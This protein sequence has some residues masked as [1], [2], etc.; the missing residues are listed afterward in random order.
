[1][2]DLLTPACPS[3]S[4]PNTTFKV[5][6]KLWEC[7][8][9]EERFADPSSQRIAVQS[10]FLSY[11]H[12]SEREEDF[13]IS[14]DLVWLIKEEL[15]RDGHLVWIDHEGIRG[16]TQW[17]ERITDAIT[18]HKHFLAFL[19]KRSV[20]QDPNVCLNEVAIAIKHNRII[21][22]I[23]TEGENRISAPLT[24]S[25]IQWHKFQDWKEIKEGKKTGPK[26][27][28]WDAWFGSLMTEIRQNLADITHQQKLGELGE[29][30]QI[31]NPISFTADIIQSVEGFFGRKWLFEAYRAWLPSNKRLFWLKGSP[32]IGK[33][34]FAAKLVH[35]GNSE[36]V[37]YFKCSFQ[38]L[39]SAEDSASECIRTLA[40]QLASR[41]PD[42]RI[43]LLRGQML[44]RET[45]QKKTADDLFTYLITEPLN[46]SE[47]IAESQRLVLVID[48]IDEAG[49]KV[50]GV[51]AN[52][53]ADLIYR[54]AEKLPNWLGIVVT[55]RPE[56]YLE[57]QLGPK[58]EP[59]VIEGGT[60]QNTQDIKEYLETKLD[61]G[62]Q[63]KERERVINA[64]IEKSGG[65]FLYIKRVELSYDLSK[66]D[67]L[68]I[69]IDD[70]FFKDFQR[71]FP[72]SNQYGE[73]TERFLRLMV[74]A[75]GPLPRELGQEVLGWSARD[76]T[77][78]VT[79]PMASMLMETGEGLQLYHKSLSEWLMDGS[80]SGIYQVNA[81]GA[82]ELGGFLWG[83]FSSEQIGDKSKVV[84]SPWEVQIRDWLTKLI[85]HTEHWQ[86]RH[87]IF[88]LAEFLDKHLKYL[89]E[90]IL[91]QQHLKLTETQFGLEHVKTA[92]SLSHLGSVLTKL[93]QYKNAESYYRR[94]LLIV[95]KIL[96]PK[97]PDKAPSLNNIGLLLIELSRYDEAATCFSEALEL[98][99]SCTNFDILETA[100][101]INNL[102]MAL[103]SL[104]RYVDSES[105]Y[106]KSLKIRENA[107]GLQHPDTAS[108]YNNLGHLFHELERFQEAESFYRK[109]LEINESFFDLEHP[110]V[111]SSLSNLGALLSDIGRYEEA[112]SYYRRALKITEK[113]FGPDHPDTAAILSLLGD[114]LSKLGRY[115]EVE[116]IYRKSLEIRKTIFGL[117]HPITAASLNNLG[118]LVQTLDRFN[119]AEDFYKKA[120]EIRE[121][122][123]GSEDPQV[124]FSLNNLGVLFRDQDRNEE[125]VTLLKRSL[126]ITK[127]N[128]GEIHSE[129][130][131]I[132]DN[133]GT[134][135]D[136]LGFHEE[137]E[138]SFRQ[139]SEI[140]I[141]IYGPEHECLAVSLDNLAST[142]R[143]Q[144]RYEEAEQVCRDS[145]RMSQNILGENH[146]STAYSMNNLSV[147]LRDMGRYD[148]AEVF[149]R[150]A[151]ESN[152]KTFGPEHTEVASS[153]SA[154][155]GLLRKLERYEEVEDLYKKILKIRELVFGVEH[156]KL[157]VNLTNLASLLNLLERYDE[158][159]TYYYRAL[160]LAENAYGKE[161]DKVA[162]IFFKLGKVQENNNKIDEAKSSYLNEIKIIQK[163]EGEENYSIAQS[164]RIIG[165]MLTDAD[166][167]DEAEPYLEKALSIAELNYKNNEQSINSQL[168]SLG[169]LRMKQLR[170]QES[171]HL[172][173]RCL[174]IEES[175]GD[176]EDI[177][178][179]KDKLVELYEAWGKSEE[180]KKY[181]D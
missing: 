141:K 52:P 72:D 23:L 19:S 173:Q 48:A 68:P 117:D 43:K 45:V 118:N 145:I 129:T 109:S 92:A 178:L 53:L 174:E 73:K 107:L 46:R 106:R 139:A 63:G 56:A 110:N 74:A 6:A 172:L 157:V 116:A 10:I 175:I 123:L 136:R 97:H 26:G 34:S 47:K 114:L 148:E 36:V 124:A 38:G 70:L 29:L 93:G 54:H 176:E 121:A 150:K 156:P 80:K 78:N 91:K 89:D 14:E 112:E 126:Q 21:Q 128:H 162:E 20:R 44:D 155:A 9:C 160:E 86:D 179:T 115:K 111:C 181:R 77:L 94:D 32:G 102:A 28:D 88:S 3:C 24:L 62:I 105:L 164:Y 108:S 113:V 83:E 165:A 146:P 41:L 42:Y 18:S 65:T 15:E 57:Q 153:M 127:A 163:N 66:P 131:M 134:V 120:L 143:S 147:I 125:A 79:Q 140:F 67:T 13:D 166:R 69:G 177:S 98:H 133:L 75:P 132:L 171:E 137:A 50:S 22:T 119:E 96:G 90:L 104:R 55:S 161:H 16:G 85:V 8:D 170:Y 159:E 99:E 31:L 25:S 152:L 81:T 51:E 49:R 138:R 4:S 1:M 103:V 130:A 82:K 58:F 37:G 158:A 12:R 60:Q 71:Y 27:E 167:L 87:S 168:Y 142:L 64:L 95:E 59:T 7:N 17:R 84:S 61:N 154:L 122:V 135:L 76:V 40:Y 180:A 144:E 101:V 5:K 169:Y 149:C 11:A 2:T 30:A 151:L 35:D 39:K 33:S 100:S